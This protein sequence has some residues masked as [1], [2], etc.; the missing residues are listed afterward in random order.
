MK[1]RFEGWQRQVIAHNHDVIP[2]TLSN[3]K[4]I[5]GEADDPLTWHAAL[6][7]FGKVND[8]ALSGSFLVTFTFSQEELRNWLQQFVQ[9][10][11]EAA[12]RL[13]A[14]MQGEAIIALAK[15][16]EVRASE[17]DAFRVEAAQAGEDM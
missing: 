2:V 8:L 11:P 17:K 13:L 1:M 4:F 3:S 15:Q 6:G 10:K 12:V 7:A 5:P 9:H 16:T 14:E